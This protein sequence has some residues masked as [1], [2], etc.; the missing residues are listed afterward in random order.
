M[1]E[2]QDWYVGY[3]RK[4]A[5]KV[6]ER[7]WNRLTLPDRQAAIDALPDHLRHWRIKGTEVDYIPHPGTW[8]NQRRWE[9]ELPGARTQ[10]PADVSAPTPPLAVVTV[11]EPQAMSA[12]IQTLRAKIGK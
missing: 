11:H 2:F 4:I 8:L 7:A 5:R 10:K 12:L 1:P 6:A 9:D 3:P